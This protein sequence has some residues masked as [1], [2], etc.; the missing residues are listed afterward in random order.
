MCAG[1][2]RPWRR[3]GS[4]YA[5]P[6]LDVVVAVVVA[7]AAAN[8]QV[9]LASQSCAQEASSRMETVAC[10]FPR[11]GT[12]CDYNFAY[13]P[14]RHRRASASLRLCSS[15][16]L[17]HDFHGRSVRDARRSEDHTPP[18]EGPTTA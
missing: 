12:E 16:A 6:G 2:V 7:A 13:V 10:N 14:H 4:E 3:S 15:V 1:Q 17:D 11:P 8:V 18:E 9:N 5:E